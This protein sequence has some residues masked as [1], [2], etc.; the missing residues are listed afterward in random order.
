[1]SKA[2]TRECDDLPDEPFIVRAA[3]TLPPGA[4]NYLTVSGEQRLREEL[5]RLFD[6]RASLIDSDNDGKRHTL[7]VVQQRIAEL[8]QSL[9]TAEV[10]PPP[11]AP[12]DRVTFGATVT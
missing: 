10:V 8:Q 11:D 3:S 2:F 1:M 6:E 4:R 5:S 9:T 12:T 7:Q